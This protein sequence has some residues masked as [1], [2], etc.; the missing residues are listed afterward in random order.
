MSSLPEHTAVSCKKG[1]IRDISAYGHQI[2][3][4]KATNCLRNLGAVI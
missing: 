1:K 3:T 2:E 4:E